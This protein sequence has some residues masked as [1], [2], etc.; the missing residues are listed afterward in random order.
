MKTLQLVL[1]FM[2]AALAVNAQE[3]KETNLYVNSAEKMLK[4][5]GKLTIGGYGE[6]NY[7]QPFGNDVRQNGKLDVQRMVLMFGYKF[8]SKVSFI[9]EIEFEHVKEVY[10][11]QAFL[12]Y[13]I[14]DNLNFRGGLLLAPMGI[15]NEYHEP[16]TFNGVARPLIDKYIAPTTWREIGAGFMGYLPDYSLKYQLYIVNGFNGF[17]G[18]PHLRGKDGLR[19][20]RQK[21]AESFMSSPNFTGK[22]EFYGIPGLNVGLSGYFGDTQST[23]YDGLD[24]DIAEDKAKADSSRV[25]IAMIGLDARYR[26]NGLQLKGQLYYTSLG[27]TGKYNNF[28]GSDLGKSMM[29]YYV[30]AGYNV[31]QHCK[32]A[33][34]ELIPFIRY[35]NY[36]TH[37]SVASGMEKNLAYDN[38]VVT[39]GLSWKVAKNAVIKTDIQFKKSKADDK[40]SK[41][42]NAGIGIMF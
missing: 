6:V 20:G 35:S 21:G 5:D 29:G 33:N 24:E 4:T 22:V 14:T 13:K 17:D 36:N 38:K 18:A 30:E 9:T 32:K 12:Q 19:K 16:T 15:T 31:F 34:T 25:N 27:N 37:E 26:T 23:L 42:F 1:V 40:Y 7:Y 28:T 10:V 3:K 41:T 8:N 2:I 39:T 11:E